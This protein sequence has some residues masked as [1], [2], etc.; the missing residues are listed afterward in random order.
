MVDRPGVISFHLAAQVGH[1]HCAHVDISN[2]LTV[3]QQT[4]SDELRMSYRIADGPVGTLHYGLAVARSVALP[5]SLLQR[6]SE[7]AAVL[8]ES[9]QRRKRSSTALAQQKRRKLILGLKEQLI[10]ARNGA[11]RGQALKLWLKR[12]QTEFVDR[13][14]DIDAEA[15][16]EGNSSDRCTEEIEETA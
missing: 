13:M 10:L 6:A 2:R 11:M 1:W 7:V 14:S 16:G 15:E 5:P 3:L 8:D 12:L 4:D 9:S